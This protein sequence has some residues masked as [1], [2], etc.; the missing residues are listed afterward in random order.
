MPKEDAKQCRQ[1]A[2]DCRTNAAESLCLLDTNAWL[3][4][5]SDWTKLAEEFE[6][7]ERPRW[8]N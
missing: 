2:E 6:K 8:L 4:L 3:D 1:A 7:E 5:A